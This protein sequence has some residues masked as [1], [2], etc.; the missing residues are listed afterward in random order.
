MYLSLRGIPP[1]W[2]AVYISPQ[3]EN[4]MLQFDNI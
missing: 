4:I 1:P 3:H 2:K